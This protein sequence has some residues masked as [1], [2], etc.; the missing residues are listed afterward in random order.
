MEDAVIVPITGRVIMVGYQKGLQN[1][2]M[3]PTFGMEFNTIRY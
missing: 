2:Y 1:V 3:D